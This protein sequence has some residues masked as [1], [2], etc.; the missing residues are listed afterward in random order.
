MIFAAAAIKKSVLI[1]Q[2][3]TLLT[4]Y[5]E[6]ATPVAWV[7][8]SANSIIGVATAAGLPDAVHAK[9]IY[10]PPSTIW[11]APGYRSRFAAHELT[12]HYQFHA[13]AFGQLD[14]SVIEREADC[15][16]QLQ[17]WCGDMRQSM[18]GYCRARD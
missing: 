2:C 16:E 13:G 18:G 3:V 12:H 4:G 14:R 9:A 1:A 11:H 10:L 6:P 15:V 17:P 8:M 7:E 5:P